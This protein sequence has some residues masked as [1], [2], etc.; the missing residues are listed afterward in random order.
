MQTSNDAD[1]D[2]DERVAVA[3]PPAESTLRDS[4]KPP[5]KTLAERLVMTILLIICGFA[6]ASNLLR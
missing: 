3:T 1:G 6:I 5:K 4:A 2:D